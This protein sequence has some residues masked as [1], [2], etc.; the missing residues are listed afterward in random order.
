MSTSGL[1]VNRRH[2]DVDLRTP[3]SELPFIRYTSRSIIGTTIERHLR[4]YRLAVPRRLD[5]ASSASLPTMVS[6]GL[7]C[8]VT[9]P[10]CLLQGYADFKTIHASPTTAAPITRRLYVAARANE[11]GGTIERIRRLAARHAREVLEQAYTG[12]LSWILKRIDLGSV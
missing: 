5:F 3:A 2:G 1:R 10:L 6:A 8:A 12:R 4:R 7:G 9:T 11:L